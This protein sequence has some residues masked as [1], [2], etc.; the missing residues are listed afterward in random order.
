MAAAGLDHPNIVPVF[1]AGEE[2]PFCF[3]ASAY[4]PGIT[5]AAWLRAR[6][7][8][9]PHRIAA[10]LVATLAEAVE[11][12]HRRGV[13]HRDLKPSNVLLEMPSARDEDVQPDDDSLDL[14][15][16]VTDFGLAK[17]LDD[18]QTPAQPSI[19]HSPESSSERRATWRQNRPKASAA[20]SARRPTFLA[21]A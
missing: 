4:C 21:W 14:V 16:R 13:L 12:A 11:H 17:L 15:P 18:A 1:E 2:G 5:L 19:P 9:V 8:I 20:R 10:K 7:R 6:G 3:I